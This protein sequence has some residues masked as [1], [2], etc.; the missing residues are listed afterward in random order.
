MPKED[1]K[2]RLTKEELFTIMTDH[3]QN[4]LWIDCRET[5]TR[6]GK[7]L[8]PS[9]KRVAW[10]KTEP[11]TIFNSSDHI[12]DLSKKHTNDIAEIREWYEDWDRTV[13]T[14]LAEEEWPAVKLAQ[15]TAENNREAHQR[16]MEREEKKKAAYRKA[17]VKEVE[18]LG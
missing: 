17:R 9:Y 7:V 4:R 1:P 6:S 5:Y 16:K 12:I 2:T 13:N 18:V 3:R 14:K 8:Q 10:P 15:K 11:R